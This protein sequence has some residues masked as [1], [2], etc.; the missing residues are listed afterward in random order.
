[1]IADRGLW[2]SDF[3]MEIDKPSGMMLPDCSF[4]QIIPLGFKYE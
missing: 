3:G 2:I 4:G 1:L